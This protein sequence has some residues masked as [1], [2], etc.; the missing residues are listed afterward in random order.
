MSKRHQASRRK[1]Y[2]RRQHELHER[3]ERDASRGR[4]PASTSTTG[5]RRAPADPLA[6]LDPRSPRFRFA[7]GRL[8][9]AVYQGARPRTIALP[10]APT[11]RGRRRRRCRAVGPRSAVRARRGPTRVSGS[12]S[13]AIVVAFMRGVLLAGPERPR[14]GHGYDIG[15]LAA[16]RER[17]DAEPPGPQLGPEPPGREPAIRKLAL[18]A[19]L[20]QLG[21]P[22]IIPAR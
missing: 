11:G 20:G 14:R 12:S 18:D 9:M 8:T 4:P 16:E 17:L 22:L 2:G 6:F 5:A 3:H 21:E 7:L 15:R 10:R 19:G 13:A 1:T